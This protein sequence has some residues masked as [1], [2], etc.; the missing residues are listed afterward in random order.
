MAYKEAQGAQACQLPVAY[1][2]VLAGFKVGQ[3][4]GAACG[5]WHDLEA[6]VHEAFGV[7]LREY[8]PT[9]HKGGVRRYMPDAVRASPILGARLP[10]AN[11]AASGGT[12]HTQELPG[13]FKRGV[14]HSARHTMPGTPCRTRRDVRATT[15]MHVKEGGELLAPKKEQYTFF[16]E[17]E[18]LIDTPPPLTPLTQQRDKPCS[19]TAL[20]LPNSCCQESRGQKRMYGRTRH[21]P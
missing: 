2:V 19:C 21:S 16:P 11:S 3:R 9:A 5:D 13:A 14:S 1:L 20:R 7:Q 17:E 4:G 18:M 10:G 8:P 15:L 6:L 12:H